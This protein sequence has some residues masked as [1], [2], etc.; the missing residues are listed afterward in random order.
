ME[1]LRSMSGTRYWEIDALRGTA[2]VMMVV[3]HTVFA[4]NFFGAVMV[5]VVSGFWRVF[6]LATATLFI[7]IAGVSISVS[8]ARAAAYL[9]RRGVALKNLWRGAGLFLLGMGISLVTWLLLP[10]EFILFGVLHCIG[11]SVALSPL[12]LPS[13]RWAILAGAIVILL[14]PLSGL[15]EGPL[16]LAWLGIHP[17]NFASLDYVP[18]IPWLGVFLAGMG[19]GASLYPAGRRGFPAREEERPPLRPVTFLGRHSLIIYL[20]HVPVILLALSLLVPG[21]GAR[22][23]SLLPP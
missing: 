20:I 15:A 23:L 3:F 16:A 8:S 11:L 7:M 13:G 6:A 1:S 9:D 12:F 2:V 14:A 22:L 19:I 4:L 18:L 10:G 21:F 5:D 17:P